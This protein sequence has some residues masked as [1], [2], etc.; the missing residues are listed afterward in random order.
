MQSLTKN[1]FIEP[2]NLF[3][4][5]DLLFSFIY[6]ISQVLFL[7]SLY[8]FSYLSIF[9]LHPLM[10]F[11]F[12]CCIWISLIP[13]I[14][15]YWYNVSH[16]VFLFSYCSFLLFPLHSWSYIFHSFSWR[17]LYVTVIIFPCYNNANYRKPSINLM[18]LQ[19]VRSIG[20]FQVSAH[21]SIIWTRIWHLWHLSGHMVLGISKHWLTF[22]L[23]LLHSSIAT[24]CPCLVCSYTMPC[25]HAL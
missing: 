24:T 10:W 20:L 4:L 12:L 22:G 1:F 18:S 21:F 25:F 11:I 19:K 16:A 5:L 7:Y 6:D 14:F 13:I 23:T 3:F 2:V 17:L 8:C 9:K 15:P